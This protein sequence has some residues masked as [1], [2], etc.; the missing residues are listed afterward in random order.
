MKL[1]ALAIRDV[2]VIDHGGKIAPG[3]GSRG[4]DCRADRDNLPSARDDTM[5]AV[6]SWLGTRRRRYPGVHATPGLCAAAGAAV[7]D[8]VDGSASLSGVAAEAAAEP[9]SHAAVTISTATNTKT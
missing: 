9:H 5:G 6:R 8:P 2:T 4:N 3:Q 1:L 7:K